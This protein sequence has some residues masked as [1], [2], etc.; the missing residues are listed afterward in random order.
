MKHEPCL[1]RKNEHGDWVQQAGP[2]VD[3]KTAGEFADQHVS[4]FPDE[5][6]RIQ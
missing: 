5:E 4:D 2:F 1:Y 3:W 6:Y